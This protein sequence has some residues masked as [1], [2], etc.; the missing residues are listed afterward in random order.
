MSWSGRAGS[1]PHSITLPSS[2]LASVISTEPKV[3][4]I[5]INAPIN[6]QPG[7]FIS[8]PSD[9]LNC[10]SCDGVCNFSDFAKLIL[11]TCGVF[12]NTVSPSSIKEAD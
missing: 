10:S 3:A 11:C 9:E 2:R 7:L 1:F 12:C 6:S 5:E 4:D 8:V